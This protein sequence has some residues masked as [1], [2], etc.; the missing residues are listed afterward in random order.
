M[1]NADIPFDDD[2]LDE[3]VLG[4]SEAMPFKWAR[5]SR[6]IHP[7]GPFNA[8]WLFDQVIQGNIESV[9]LVPR[10]KLL[11]VRVVNLESLCALVTRL[12]QA[13]GKPKKA[14]KARPP[15]FAT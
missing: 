7:I 2:R 5:Y 13:P 1:P 14:K 10:H 8:S 15:K 4:D 12:A 3:F 11:G 9:M 6:L